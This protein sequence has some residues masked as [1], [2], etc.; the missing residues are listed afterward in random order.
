MAITNPNLA[1]PGEHTVAAWLRRHL[2]WILTGL[3][4][5]AA[6]VLL[7]LIVVDRDSAPSGV[8]EP[9]AGAVEHESITAIDHRS[10]ANPGA[11]RESTTAIDH[12]TETAGD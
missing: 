9:G 4:V 1:L 10:E 3:G 2:G 12:R 8:V 7:S 5:V 11:D 6:M